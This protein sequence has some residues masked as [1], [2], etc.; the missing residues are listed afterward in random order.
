MVT[1]SSSIGQRLIQEVKDIE[2][3]QRFYMVTSPDSNMHRIF[4]IG[5]KH[6][7]EIVDGKSLSE[8]RN[9]ALNI[10]T[11]SNVEEIR[12]RIPSCRI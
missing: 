6:L 8:E 12:N 9:W 2:N 1:Y 7:P 4:L 5:Q 11:T 3:V 10:L